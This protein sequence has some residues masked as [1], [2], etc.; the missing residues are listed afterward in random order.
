[1]RWF[2]G[3]GLVVI[4]CLG[5]LPFGVAGAE[6]DGAPVLSL[7]AAIALALLDNPSVQIAELDVEQAGDHINAARADY[8]PQMK[9]TVRSYRNLDAQSYTIDQGALGTFA[10]T[11]PIP[12]TD[13][14][15]GTA[16]RWTKT[17]GLTIQQSLSGI[18]QVVMEVEKLSVQ[19]RLE[20]E[21]LRSELQDTARQVK[22]KYYEIQASQSDISYIQSSIDFYVA[23]VKELGD[24]YAQQTV[25]QYE[26]LDAEARL[27]DARQQEFA[28]R[29]DIESQKEELNNLMGRATDE[30]FRVADELLAPVI[31][32][33]QQEAQDRA[34]AQ[35]PDMRSAELNVIL[36]Q[37]GVDIT[38]YGY[39]PDIDLILDYSHA[40]NNF[41]PDE[42]L[43]VGIFLS[44]EFYDWGRRANEIAAGKLSVSQ[45]QIDVV[46]TRSDIIAQ[47]NSALRD[48]QNA[49]AEV[50]VARM[51][52]IAGVERLRVTKNRYDQ[53]VELLDDLFDAEEDLNEANNEYVE[54][55][56]SVLNAQ[57]ELAQAMGEE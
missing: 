28:K 39:V 3:F 23:L 26:L 16:D 2:R 44:W 53:G 31:V 12:A 52:Q 17:V 33:G 11:G 37:K 7:E 29:N 48:L 56:L 25:L 50:D 38:E 5:L 4:L 30:P 54:A 18:Y 55:V 57:A 22:Q 8:F 20:A 19:E 42:S 1:M 43:Y 46:R 6:G 27:A 41:M 13:T 47:V 35:R 32:I 40:N 36:A 45:A 34:L 24:Q 10:A 49:Q 21:S 15:I 51:A 14:Q 9:A